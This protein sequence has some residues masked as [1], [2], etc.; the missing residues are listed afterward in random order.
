[1]FAYCLAVRTRSS[2]PTSESAEDKESRKN[3]KGIRGG[4]LKRFQKKGLQPH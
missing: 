1:M 4:L 3:A 2:A